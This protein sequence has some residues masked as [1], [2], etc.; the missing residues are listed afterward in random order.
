MKKYLSLLLSVLSLCL[1]ISCGSESGAASRPAL[2]HEGIPDEILAAGACS[3]ELEELDLDTAYMLYKLEDWGLSRESITGGA[4]RRSAG[5][6]CE[7]VAVL[8]M[9]STDSAKTAMEA[10]EA[11]VQGQ[12][13]AN[14]NYRPAEIPKL[15]NAWL[16]QREATLLLAVV[17][18][19]EAAGSVSK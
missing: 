13:D 3:E 8:L 16:E 18:D 19:L 11:Y 1:L 14:V 15:E 17:N 7:E 12:I 9:D 6:T 2:W 10:L 4:V 5:A